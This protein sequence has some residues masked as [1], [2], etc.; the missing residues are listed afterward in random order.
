[1]TERAIGLGPWM[2]IDNVHQPDDR[3]FQVPGAREK[4]LA[5]LVAAHNVDLTDDGWPRSRP[6]TA[7]VLALTAGRR[8]VSAGGMLLVQEGDTLLQWDPETAES[9]VLLEDLVDADPY[10]HMVEYQ[11]DVLVTDGLQCRRIRAGL[12]GS[13]GLEVPPEPDLT[14]VAGTLPA[15]R[16]LVAV[17]ARDADGQESGA[18]PPAVLDLAAPGGIQIDP[19]IEDP[20][21]THAAIYV[22][23]PDQ[24]EPMRVAVVRL[25]ELPYTVTDLDTVR[26]KIPLVSQG[27][28]PP[29]AMMA[30]LGAFRGYVLAGVGRWVFRS[31]GLQPQWWAWDTDRTGFPAE[32]TC[33]V[34]LADGW[35]CG[36]EGGLFWVSGE[37][38]A[39]WAVTRIDSAA[40]RPGGRALSGGLFPALQYDG[41]V[42]AMVSAD[43]LLLGLPGG[44]VRRETLDRYRFGGS[45]RVSVAYRQADDL[46]QVLVAVS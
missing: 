30:A 43:G 20:L 34:G 16:Y 39:G 26:E 4:R 8:M 32:V 31:K 35:Y 17:T 33:I 19:L 42:A 41:M 3:T 21:A 13:W 14:A 15:G 44:V 9:T 5:A 6:G 12:V 10:C 18:A 45:G 23:A 24:E 2:G 29:P 7:Q 36:T 11:G 28:R 25:D 46:R 22:S 40:V 37:Q 1:M 38:P 27:L